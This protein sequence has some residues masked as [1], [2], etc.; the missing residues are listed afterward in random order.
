MA[1]ESQPKKKK[2]KFDEVEKENAL[3]NPTEGGDDGKTEEDIPIDD[4]PLKPEG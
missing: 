2:Q 4:E 1:F 3:R